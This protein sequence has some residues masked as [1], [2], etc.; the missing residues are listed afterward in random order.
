[1]DVPNF[2]GV[3]IH[4]GNNLAATRGCILV[5]EEYFENNLNGFLKYSSE[6]FQKFRNWFASAWSTDVIMLKIIEDYQ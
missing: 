5:G 1:M 3:M 2:R 6:A 4:T